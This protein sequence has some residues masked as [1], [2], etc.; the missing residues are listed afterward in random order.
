MR[1]G[2]KKPRGRPPVLLVAASVALTAL[3]SSVTG[4]TAHASGSARAVARRDTS[5]GV[6]R[7]PFGTLPN[8][9]TV[10]MYTL[11]NASGMRAKVMTHGAT[12]QKIVVPDSAGRHGT[13]APTARR[14]SRGRCRFKSGSPSA[15][16]TVCDG[17]PR[18]HRQAH[19]RN[20]TNH[21]YFNLAGEGSGD[22]YGEHLRIDANRY[23]PIDANLIP[24][25]R[26]AP[27]AGTPLD[28][29][30][31]TAIGKHIRDG[32]RQLILAHGYDHNV[33]IAGRPNGSGLPE[34][35]VAKDP[36]NGRILRVLTDQPGV[37]LYSGNFLDGS[38]AG[39]SGKTYRQG[40]GFTLETQHYPNSPNQRNSL[41]RIAAGSGVQL[42]DG[43]QVRDGE[44]TVRRKRTGTPRSG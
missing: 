18:D 13:R 33:V 42:D 15:T 44:V 22:V 24:T 11:T 10:Y 5:P 12:I 8:G 4:K 25:G 29:R 16:G 40:D 41:D 17:L 27:V 2:S 38:L 39:T 3:A 31:S 36:A 9:R 43:P 28:F 21:A 7:A 30:H 26:L 34:A 19:R 23:T 32:Y 20:L 14:T 1:H 35:A 37:Q 6:T